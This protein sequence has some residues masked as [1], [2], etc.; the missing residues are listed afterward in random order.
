MFEKAGGKSL[1]RYEEREEYNVPS[2]QD[3]RVMDVQGKE[4]NWGDVQ[5]GLEMGIP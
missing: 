4:V 5:L 3:V 2:G 1:D